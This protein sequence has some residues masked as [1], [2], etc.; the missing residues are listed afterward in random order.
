M[1]YLFIT[2][3]IALGG[4]VV[5][6]GSGSYI[7]YDHIMRDVVG[8]IPASPLVTKAEYDRRKH[9]IK[10]SVLNP[11]TLPLTIVEKGF[12]FKPGKETEEKAYKVTGLPADVILPPRSTT[13]VYLKLREGTEALK[14]GDTV[15][16]TFTYKH[17]LSEDLYTVT[18]IF[19]KRQERGGK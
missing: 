11:G 19:T 8:G 4:F 9:R 1:R 10:Y 16:V 15:V 18:H 14:A 6:G 17:L 7:T 2:V 5:G 3:T 12:V 13:L